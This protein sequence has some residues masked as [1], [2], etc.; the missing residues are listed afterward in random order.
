MQPQTVT[1]Q[2]QTIYDYMKLCGRA[3]NFIY[4]PISVMLSR[5]MEAFPFR[6]AALL[7]AT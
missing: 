1:P 4:V 6:F 3:H 7:I 5:F 2:L